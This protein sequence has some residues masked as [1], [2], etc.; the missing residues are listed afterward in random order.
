M[1]W[2]LVVKILSSIDLWALV[3]DRNQVEGL[4]VQNAILD[5][6]ISNGFEMYEV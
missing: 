2:P 4:S 5:M 6:W 1:N 3:N